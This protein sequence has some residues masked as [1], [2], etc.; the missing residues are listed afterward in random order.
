MFF[1]TREDAES[2]LSGIPW[3]HRC[4]NNCVVDADGM[5]KPTMYVIPEGL[6]DKPVPLALLPALPQKIV[7]RAKGELTY[8]K[9]VGTHFFT[10]YNDQHK[11]I[12]YY[13]LMKVKSG[14]AFVG[15]EWN[16]LTVVFSRFMPW[17]GMNDRMLDSDFYLRGRNIG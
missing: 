12:D 5:E 15:F 17:Y 16:Q 13:S 9:V 14:A 8:G 10:Y 7:S 2:H 1:E 11:R 4:E 3:L 6:Y